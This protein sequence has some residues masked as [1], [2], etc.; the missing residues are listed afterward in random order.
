MG[1]EGRGVRCQAKERLS[2]GRSPDNTESMAPSDSSASG[3]ADPDK[4]PPRPPRILLLGAG[5]RLGAALVRAWSGR[6]QVEALGRGDIDVADGIALEACLRGR[7]F[8]ILVN[9]TGLTNVDACEVRRSEALAVNT[10]APRIM[11]AAASARGARLVHFSTDYVF[12]GEKEAPYVEGDPAR[13]LGWYGATKLA[14]EEAVLADAPTHAV[15]RVAWVFGRDKAAFPDQIVARARA[16]REVL[17]VADKFSCP[18]SACDLAG[19]LEPFFSSSLPGGLYHACNAGSCSWQEYGQWALEC[20]ASAGIPL[21]ATTV[22]PQRLADMKCFTARRP[23]HTILS[24]E[25][26]V[27]TTGLVPRSWREA[28]RDHF[29]YAPIPPA[30]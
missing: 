29:D 6:F 8:D 7:P 13:P 1:R 18:T 30:C 23:V 17:A 25:K 26:L 20:A 21:R 9:G 12:D 19:W 14:G 11:A 2:H 27:R 28:L 22:G 15:F 10:V 4:R 16:E 3:P 5:G 24:T